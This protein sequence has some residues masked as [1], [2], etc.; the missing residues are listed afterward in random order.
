MFDLLQS[1]HGLSFGGVGVRQNRDAVHTERTEA[2]QTE[3]LSNLGSGN[4]LALVVDVPFAH[5]SQTDVRDHAQ[6]IGAFTAARRN[7][8]IDVVVDVFHIGI[9]SRFAHA[10]KTCRHLIDA[11]DHGHLGESIGQEGFDACRL[12]AH[13]AFVEFDRSR[14]V[15]FV[16]NASA[17]HALILEV[18]VVD[19]QTVDVTAVGGGIDRSTVA[20]LEALP[21]VGADFHLF[22]RGGNGPKFI[23]GERLAVESVRCGNGTAG[24]HRHDSQSGSRSRQTE[25]EGL[26][27]FSSL[28]VVL[29]HWNLV[30]FTLWQ[31]LQRSLLALCSA[32]QAVHSSVSA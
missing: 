7:Q 24:K 5:Q 15:R 10:G 27:H 23:D 6:V 26:S 9:G 11:N 16:F 17:G 14:A 22:A 8:R 29:S 3:F 18:A 21:A 25:L 31:V 4:A 32:W 2:L 20:R 13:L 28:L 30:H 1:S 19:G 12:N